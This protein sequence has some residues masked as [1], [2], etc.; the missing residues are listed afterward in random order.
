[1][2]EEDG[3]VADEDMLDPMFKEAS[4]ASEK[5][6][7]QLYIEQTKLIYSTDP[8]TIY[9]QHMNNLLSPDALGALAFLEYPST[10]TN[11]L[12]PSSSYKTTCSE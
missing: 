4:T 5:R 9:S 10:S 6:V 8:I 3:P 11:V 2:G 12:L 7:P 1:L